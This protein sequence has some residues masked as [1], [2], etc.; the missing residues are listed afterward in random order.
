MQ[1]RHISL[2]FFFFVLIA[3][4]GSSLYY[5]KVQ[6][7]DQYV[8]NEATTAGS[9]GGGKKIG[10]TE[11]AQAN[12]KAVSN[13]QPALSDASEQKKAQRAKDWT[14]NTVAETDSTLTTSTDQTALEV[15]KRLIE[16][17]DAIDAKRTQTERLINDKGVVAE[18]TVEVT[19]QR[20][21]GID[22]DLLNA[23]DSSLDEKIAERSS[24]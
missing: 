15:N 8:G 17:M 14:A 18:E 1:N 20:V 5:L 2:L 23:L 16:A 7:Y 11:K 10:K 19:T 22:G 9:D 6:V 21:A 13:T 12:L 4:T 3:V 24:N